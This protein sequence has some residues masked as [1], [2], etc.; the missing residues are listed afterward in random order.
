MGTHE[1]SD[2]AKELLYWPLMAAKDGNVILSLWYSHWWQ[3]CHAFINNNIPTIMQATPVKLS[4]SLKQSSKVEVDLKK[5]LK[6]GN[7]RG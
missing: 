2:L 4:E 6:E 3:I 7:K 1:A 5:K